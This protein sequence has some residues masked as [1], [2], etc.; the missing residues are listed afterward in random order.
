MNEVFEYS[1]PFLGLV[2]SA[3]K[4]INCLCNFIFNCSLIIFINITPFVL[5]NICITLNCIKY[6]TK[7][8]YV[9][10]LL[11]FYIPSVKI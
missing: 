9:F 2:I 4:Y 10:I 7:I 11:R 6:C 1:K 8:A 5:N 3:K